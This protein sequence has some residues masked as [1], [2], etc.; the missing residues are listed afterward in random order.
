M[1]LH[2][3]LELPSPMKRVLK[4]TVDV[5]L[6]VVCL[7]A[8]HM[9]R[10]GTLDPEIAFRDSWMLFPATVLLGAGLIVAFKLPDGGLHTLGG[11]L[12]LRI[13]LVAAGLSVSSILVSY[14]LGLSGPRTV[15]LIFGALFFL[16]SVTV[17]VLFLHLINLQRR[18]S[19]DALP[20]A[21]YGAGA[22]G[23]QIALA[24][25]QSSETDPVF[26]VDDDPSLHGLMIAGLPV[27]NPNKLPALLKRH[28]IRRVL[29]A[30]PSTPDSRREQLASD[31][32]ETGI[33]V[34][35]LPSYVELVAS[36]RFDV[37][38]RPI[39]PD[40]LLARDTVELA[41]AEVD[42]AYAGRVV[43]VT[44][45]GGSI[46]A[47]LCRQLL[48]CKPA[49]L[50]LFERN[51]VALYSIDQDLRRAASGHGVKI[52]TRIG[53]VTDKVRVAGVIA[54][55]GVDV[56]LHAA[57]YKHVPMVEE[58]ALE[59]AGNN[60]LGTKVLADVADAQE[61][62][63]VILISTDKA[64]RPTNMMGATKRMA[65]LVIQDKQTRSSKTKFSV[66]RFGSVLGASGS[67][68][69][70]LQRQIETG[71]PV[72]LP[73]RDAARFFMTSSTAA[74]LLLL[75]SAYA[76]GG[77]VFVLGA[78]KPQKIADIVQRLI[79][80]SGYSVKDPVTGQGEIAIEITGLRPGEKLVEE[81]LIDLEPLQATPHPRI[82]RAKEDRVS[83]TEIAMMIRDIESCITTHAPSRLRKIVQMHVD[84]Y[85]SQHATPAQ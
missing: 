55:E 8:A 1:L 2:R 12:I 80:H 37:K 68:I 71:G 81:P 59:G 38:P 64:A 57:G 29:L 30:I 19:R 15:P 54:T 56:I 33:E 6:V 67:L 75:A 32:A 51:E 74:R 14:M 53:S 39:T 85:P 65:E 22:G 72:T 34:Q 63:R 69:P 5:C 20:V 76:E 17:R 35:V 27:Y 21:I 77:D 43:M 46:G 4:F 70:L 62:E 61:V 28:K 82:L 40:Q 7:A 9:L 42:A 16:A 10:Y 31:L 26:F 83:Q 84:G 36:K 13:A 73:H 47:E 18:H 24:L 58:N 23:R 11:P 25:N 49:A 48:S 3:L 78:G 41:I 79:E 52:V 60:V 66:V 50:V 44:G 45:A